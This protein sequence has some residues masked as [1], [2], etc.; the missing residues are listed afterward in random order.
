MRN[1]LARSIS[2]LL[3]AQPFLSPAFVFSQQ[4]VRQRRTQTQV[5]PQKTSSQTDS[6]EWQPPATPAIFPLDPAIPALSR[7]EPTIRVA[8]ATD[9]RS[10]T[11]STSGHLMNATDVATTLVALDVARVRLEPRLLS[12]LPPSDVADAYQIQIAALPSLAEAEQKSRE[13][14]EVTGEDSQ[15]AYDT[16]TKTWRLLV[17]ARH[18]RIEAE[19]FRAR[20]E[21]AGIDAT[22][23]PAAGA[24]PTVHS[25]A[26]TAVMP[27]ATTLQSTISNSW[28]ASA[29]H[30][31]RPAARFSLPSR[32]VVASAPGAGHLFSSSAPVTFASDSETTPV[33]FNDRPYRGRIEVFANTR[34]ALTVVNVLGLEDYVKGVVPN[35]LSPGGFPLLEAHKA[36]AIA[37]RTYALRNRGQFLSQGFDLLPTTRSQV[38]RGIASETALSTRA[39][40][41]TRGIIA[42]Y[43]GEPI[44][45]LYTSTCGGRTEDAGNIFNQA[46]P[47]LRARECAAEARAMF[48]PFILRTS[49]EPAELHEE[50]NLSLAR[51]MALLS[52]LNFGALSPR[53]SDNWL[54]APVSVSE[55][56]SWLWSAALL[57]HQAMPTV[58]DDL[59]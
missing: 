39:V 51:D 22:I 15:V 9:A 59:K 13:V 2:A 24:S 1:F 27:P 3:L 34:G 52:V 35:E 5:E 25:T 29:A 20:L 53:I 26:T 48:E 19:E 37:A 30:S 41:Q 47:Y 40:D 46:V 6:R 7:P 4:E 36:Q 28:P 21:D 44:N 23:L 54:S 42:T 12:P 45:A 11:I 58:S 33:R 57:A 32:E 14:R 16:E 8:L 18:P 49:R 43:N 17:G 10:A 50:K 56:R 55:V 31:V 38:Y